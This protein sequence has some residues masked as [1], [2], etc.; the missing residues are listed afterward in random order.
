MPRKPS[1]FPTPAS[2]VEATCPSGIPEPSPTKSDASSSATK[3]FRR[4]R[5]IKTISP[6]MATSAS[7]RSALGEGVW[8]NIAHQLYAE[9]N[10]AVKA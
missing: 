2:K 7:T 9:G 8:E 5:A 10:A 3:A 6:M 4:N 1:V